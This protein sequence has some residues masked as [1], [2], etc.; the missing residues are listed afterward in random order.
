MGKKMSWLKLK[1]IKSFLNL[2]YQDLIKTLEVA[3]EEGKNLENF[4]RH[5]FKNRAKYPSISQAGFEEVEKK[6]KELTRTSFIPTEDDI[7][8]L[9]EESYRLMKEKEFTGAQLGANLVLKYDPDNPLALITKRISEL[10]E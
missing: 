4:M 9:A 6:Y 2:T 7:T 3:K 5:F 10:R 8:F 1:K